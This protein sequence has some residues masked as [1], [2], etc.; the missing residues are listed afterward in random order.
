M[1]VLLLS[2]SLS[3]EVFGQFGLRLKYNQNNVDDWTNAVNNRYQTDKKLFNTGYEVGVDYWFRLKERRIEFMPEISYGTSST[4][5]NSATN[6]KDISASTLGF[7]FH[8]QLY[9]LD[10]EGDCNCPT[11]SKEG[12]S[13]NKGLFIHLSPGIMYQK[14]S[15]QHNPD[16]LID[17]ADDQNSNM[18]GKLGVGVGL[19]VG[20]SDLITLTPIVSYYFYSNMDW[21]NLETGVSGVMSTASTN[22]TQLQFTL[23]LG[24]RPD[25]GRRRFR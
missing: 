17:F 7:T 13:I 11:F 5:Y 25:Y 24:F 6:L 21:E 9:A 20:V 19:D 15:L 2:I 14:S 1:F 10:L 22:L 16:P 8:T 18:V 12:P 4:S 23:R 3:H